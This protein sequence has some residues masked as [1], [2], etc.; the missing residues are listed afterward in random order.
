M[1]FCSV[2]MQKHSYHIASPQSS[3]G[4]FLTLNSSAR[5]VEYGSLLNNYQYYSFGFLVILILKEPN[6][7]SNY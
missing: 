7:Y 3:T 5:A 2:E 1:C 4:G 6:S